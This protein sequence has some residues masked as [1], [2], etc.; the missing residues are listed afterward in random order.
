MWPCE[1]PKYL[2]PNSSEVQ[3]DYII[4]M[5]YKIIHVVIRLWPPAIF[6][7]IWKIG[8]LMWLIICESGDS[9]VSAT[10]ITCLSRHIRA[11]AIHSASDLHE[12]WTNHSQFWAGLV[13]Q[14]RFSYPISSLVC[15]SCHIVLDRTH[16]RRTCNWLPGTLGNL[17]CRGIR[18]PAGCRLWTRP[19]P[20]TTSDQSTTD[21]TGQVRRCRTRHWHSWRSSSVRVAFDR[22]GQDCM[23][24]T[25]PSEQAALKVCLS[26]YSITPGKELKT[27]FV[28]WRL[29]FDYENQTVNKQVHVIFCKWSKSHK[30]CLNIL[31][32]SWTIAWWWLNGI[33]SKMEASLS[34]IW[35]NG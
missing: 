11:A 17:S 2:W 24:T 15:T 5:R 7:I 27:Q 22:S 35:L 16:L 19:W 9:H 12:T 14:D 28:I 34:S 32:Y 10:S 30:L 31:K 20:R 3:K 21:R 8:N 4:I 1:I 25:S 13:I 23:S 33:F 26:Q 29:R 6:N 18:V